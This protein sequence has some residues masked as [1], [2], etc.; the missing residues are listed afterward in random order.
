M[1]NEIDTQYLTENLAAY[2]F[3]KSVMRNCHDSNVVELLDQA[4]DLHDLI[5]L[6]RSQERRIFAWKTPSSAPMVV[7]DTVFLD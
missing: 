3:R 7:A 4:D 6:R 1:S 5:R 2:T